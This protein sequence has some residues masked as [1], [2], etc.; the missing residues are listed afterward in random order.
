MSWSPFWKYDIIQ[1]N[2]DFIQSDSRY[3]FSFKKN[4][5][6]RFI[7]DT[8]WNNVALGFLKS[9]T[10][11]TRKQQHEQSVRMP[12][13]LQLLFKIQHQDKFE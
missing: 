2:L 12:F 3:I 10:S 5:H 13:I 1:N 8:I 7:P 6:T 11:T 9:I 4:N